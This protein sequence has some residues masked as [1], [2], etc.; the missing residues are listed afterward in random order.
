[1]AR[2][3][4][5]EVLQ[6]MPYG[7][8]GITSAT[9]DDMNA[10]VANWVTQTSFQPRLVVLGLQKSSYTHG[11]VQKGNAFAINIFHERDKELLTPFLKGRAKNPDKMREAEYRRAPLT[12]CPVLEGAAA[13]I[14][15][16]VLRTIDIGG[17]HDIVVGEAI[18]GEVMK[19]GS[20]SDTLMLTDLGWSYAG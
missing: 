11:L 17:D 14:E 19:P 13:Y 16:R 4:V 6:M 7:F 5:K 3:E 9:D 12:G 2:D 1:M 8:Y 10:M 15:C 18:G 20:V